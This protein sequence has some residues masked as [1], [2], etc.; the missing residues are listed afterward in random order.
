[1]PTSTFPFRSL[2]RELRD[3]IYE[4]HLS[5]TYINCRPNF[6]KLPDTSFAAHR[7][8]PQQRL[9]GRLALLLVSKAVHAE[10]KPIFYKCGTFHFCAPLIITQ[11]RHSLRD[12]AHLQH[13]LIELNFD[14]AFSSPFYDQYE[15][16][17][18]IKHFAQL[19]TPTLTTR[20]SCVVQIWAPLAEDLLLS[21]DVDPLPIIDAIG[22]L[23]GY[24]TVVLKLPCGFWE[25]RVTGE[26]IKAVYEN[27]GKYLE[28]WLG[29]KE[30]GGD[31]VG[32]WGMWF[33]WR[34]HPRE[35]REGFG[36]NE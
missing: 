28:R 30:K 18:L 26:V 21:W 14:A 31:D 19:K 5:T 3:Q 13:I 25:Q 7:E 2:P 4:H 6:S 8:T 15:A 27:L 11:L 29:K 1:M 22:T 35:G 16:A 12:T 33:C 23:K 10:V 20:S 9:S 24:E 17:N 36:R 32:D 34:F